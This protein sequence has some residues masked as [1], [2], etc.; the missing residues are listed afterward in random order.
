MSVPQRSPGG[1]GGRHL[2]TVPPGVGGGTVVPG[3]GA[4][5]GGGKVIP[6]AGHPPTPRTNTSPPHLQ[7]T[8]Y[9]PTMSCVTGDGTWNWGAAS[10]GM[11]NTL[12]PLSSDGS[13]QRAQHGYRDLHASIATP[14]HRIIAWK[15]QGTS[16]LN[17]YPPPP[18]S[19]PSPCPSPPP[20]GGNRHLADEQ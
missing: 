13:C 9:V 18:V 17:N 4:G 1:G 15:H 6:Q 2:V 8:N 7:D 11:P 20:K 16:L 5:H 3:G 14:R 19:I 10:C 12:K